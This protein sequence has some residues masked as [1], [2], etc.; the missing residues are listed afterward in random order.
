MGS[1]G[2]VGFLLGSHY[3]YAL[4]REYWQESTT[5][6]FFRLSDF[7][8]LIVYLSFF[9][10]LLTF[11]GLPIHIMRDVFLTLRSFTKRILDF[12]RY[13]RA[14]RDMNERYP[15]AS[16]EEIGREEVCIICR[17]EMRPWPASNQRTGQ[18]G[19]NNNEQLPARPATSSVDER[20]RPKKLPCGHILHFGCLRSWLERQQI[21]PTCRRPVMVTSRITV[22][23]ANPAAVNQ[24]NI[25]AV[26][27]I[28]PPQQPQQAAQPGVAQ[29]GRQ[30]NRG[31]IFNF[32]PIRIGYGRGNVF[33]DLVQ[34]M[35]NGQAGA[36]QGANEDAQANNNHRHQLSFGLGFGRP[37]RPA[38]PAPTEQSTVSGSEMHNSVQA[39][40]QQL[41]QQINAEISSLRVTADQLRLVR[42]LQGEMTRLRQLH[43]QLGSLAAGTQIPVNSASDGL[44]PA[45]I[46]PRVQMIGPNWVSDVDGQ[47]G[48]P[49]GLSLPPGWTL[50]P[51]HRANSPSYAPQ[52]TSSSMQAQNLPFISI[53]QPWHPTVRVTSRHQSHHNRAD[54][55]P[56]NNEL[57]RDGAFHASE[58][59]PPVSA[60]ETQ[61]ESAQDRFRVTLQSPTST[62]DN[63]EAS[64]PMSSHDRPDDDTSST[65]S[66][67]AWGSQ[68][69][70]SSTDK[71]GVS[72]GR[73]SGVAGQDFSN[74]QGSSSTGLTSRQDKGKGRAAT[75]EDYID[76]V[77]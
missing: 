52:S 70:S 8:K 42:V 56:S 35:Q 26:G 73:A 23:P 17:E 1:E 58:S 32:G 22:V 37:A 24:A 75:V 10:I 4:S 13:R 14:T 77:D 66:I 48:L 76:D 46:P 25:P 44:Q 15:D 71:Q 68:A 57:P 16:A 33:Q 20:H 19:T 63:Q 2:A 12:L 36:F 45:M 49:P 67:P 3:R 59:S 69:A 47:S 5:L 27:R 62:G 74:G 38:N 72:E 31:R 11:Y 30:P 9:S 55:T 39:Q 41:E 50:T 18:D 65:V 21:C 29:E 43:D 54:D 60:T 34:Q 51:L 6:T 61:R 53:G 28:G 40:L 7:L 64:R